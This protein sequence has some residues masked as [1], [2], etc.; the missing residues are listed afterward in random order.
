MLTL[1]GLL[2]L[3][4]LGACGDSGKRPLGADCSASDECLSGLCVAGA[5]LDPAADD[6][7]D[8]LSNGL[9]SALGSNPQSAD[10]DADGLS[11]PDELAI[12]LSLHD[13]DG[14]GRADVIESAMAD[15]DGDCVTDQYDA[16][17][18]TPASDVSAMVPAVCPHAGICGEQASRL[19]AACPDGV[20]AICVFDEVEG[21]ADPERACDGRDENCD[22]RVDEADRCR[23]AQA[24]I[25]PG[26]GGTT[27]ATSRYRATLVLGQPATSSSRSA[28]HV[29]HLGGNP[30]V[31]PAESTP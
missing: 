21:Y 31:S 27:A 24:F 9:E 8:G 14:D 13:I 26:S 15:A 19:R 17:D 10:S 28:R 23:R 3:G 20:T 29:F 16:D 4:A 25:A 12:D 18:R 1:A 7:Q 5:C 22:G 30:V 2:A 6:D 11:D